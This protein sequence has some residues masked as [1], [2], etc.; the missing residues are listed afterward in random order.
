MRDS[1]DLNPK[2]LDVYLRLKP[3]H[4]NQLNF[5]LP[6]WIDYYKSWFYIGKI[7]QFKFNSTDSTKVELIKL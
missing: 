2:Q 6:I 3:I 5:S 4:I 1:L 7:S